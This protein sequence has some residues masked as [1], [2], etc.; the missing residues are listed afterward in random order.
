MLEETQTMREELL[1]AAKSRNVVNYS[2]VAPSVGLNMEL[3]HDRNQ[4]ARILDGIS[5]AEHEAGR[6]LLSA[7]V[8]RIDKNMPGNGFFALARR[9]GLHR[10]GDKFD[11]WSEEL[12]RV[13]DHWAP[14]A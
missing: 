2:D 4:I 10:A 14:D 7:V 3:A 5:Q 6:P 1:K 8:I 12:K 13:Y 11:Y 9:L